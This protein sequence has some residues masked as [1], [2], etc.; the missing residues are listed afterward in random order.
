MILNYFDLHCDTIEE[1]YLHRQSLWENN[2]MLSL[3]RG[4]NYAPWFQLFAVWIPDTCRGEDAFDFFCSVYRKFKMELSLHAGHILQCRTARDMETAEGQGRCGALLA[5]EGGAVLGGE[6]NRVR[7]LA[8]CGVRAVTL[9]WNGNCELGD[10]AMV[11]NPKGL[12]AFG[13]SAVREMENCGIVIDVSHASD[14]LFYDVAELTAKPFI[15]THSDARSI[16]GHKR[17]LT[18]EQFAIIRDRGGLVGINLC[19]K[20]LNDSGKAGFADI[21]RHVEHF[22]SL[23]GENTLALGTDFDGAAMSEGISGIESMEE[24]ADYFAWH[25]Y[26]DSL[27]NALFYQNA[28]RFFLSL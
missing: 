26:G 23:G 2:L 15:A 9:T 6:L 20:F 17:N 13:K 14:P 24:L 19:P 5:V 12:T 28:R 16:C 22:L 25:Q 8:D 27:I 18:D 1:C 4:K 3:A 7:R 10:G 21:L 11:E